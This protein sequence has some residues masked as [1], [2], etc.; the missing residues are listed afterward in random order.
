VLYHEQHRESSD[1]LIAAAKQMVSDKEK[2][3]E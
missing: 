2:L 1:A 3:S